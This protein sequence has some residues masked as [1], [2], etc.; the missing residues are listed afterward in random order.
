MCAWAVRDFSPKI[1][2]C[3]Q[4][5]RPDNRL[6]LEVADHIVCE[7]ELRNALLASTCHCPGVGTLV[8]ITMV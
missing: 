7:G 6:H 2:L 5:L 3:V 8:R 4:I 1:K